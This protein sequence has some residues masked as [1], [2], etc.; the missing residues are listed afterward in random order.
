[1]PLMY[2]ST[3][4]YIFASINSIIMALKKKRGTL[5]PHNSSIVL[6]LA[7]I[8]SA[9]NIVR[10]FAFLLKIGIS[11]NTVNKMLKGEA[12]QINFRQ[13]TTLCTHLNCTPNDLFAIRN[14]DLPPNHQLQQLQSVEE[15]VVNPNAFFEGKSLEEIKEMLRE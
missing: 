10:P 11:T 9:R 2:K 13:L 12:V 4:L 8:L 7:P 3:I 15:A 14:I 5:K 1:M 6:H